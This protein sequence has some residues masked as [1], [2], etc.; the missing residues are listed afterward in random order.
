[1]IQKI[2]AVYRDD[3]IRETGFQ[4]LLIIQKIQVGT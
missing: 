1:M 4:G 3:L 2:L